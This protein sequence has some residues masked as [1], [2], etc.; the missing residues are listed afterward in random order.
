MARGEGREG[1]SKGCPRHMQRNLKHTFWTGGYAEELSNTHARLDEQAGATDAWQMQ[2]VW[3]D[4]SKKY[5]GDQ[6]AQIPNL[7]FDSN[8]SF[9]LILGE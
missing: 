5:H 6:E 7:C 1:G 9:S 3:F 4:L 2:L 8:S